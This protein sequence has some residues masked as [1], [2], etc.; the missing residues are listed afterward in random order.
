MHLKI[1]GFI[2]VFALFSGISHAQIVLDPG[3]GLQ[4]SGGGNNGFFSGRGTV[5]TAN[6]DLLLTGAGVW[7]NPLSSFTHS[8]SL[9]QTNTYPGNV[10]NTLLAVGSTTSSDLG[11][12]F[13]N[14]IFSSPVN[15]TAGNRYH[16]EVMH[17]NSLQQNF[18]YSFNLGSV[19]LGPVTVEDG[20]LGGSTTNGVMPLLRLNTSSA[21]A[22]EPGA[23][24]FMLLGVTLAGLFSRR[25]ASLN[26]A[27]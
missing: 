3:T 4:S 10:N 13:Y 6:S 2:A 21:A 19:N 9:Y 24:A 26:T 25:R 1:G 8:W 12:G 20:T 27:G 23:L 18:F 22:P 7:A 11:A 14:V 5:F 15:L 16:L 17:Q